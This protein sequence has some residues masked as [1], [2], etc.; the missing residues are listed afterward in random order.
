MKVV[1]TE[2]LSKIDQKPYWAVDWNG[3]AA[4][5]IQFLNGKFLA[6]V[7][8]VKGHVHSHEDY[9]DTLWGAVAHVVKAHERDQVE[10]GVSA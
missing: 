7:T 2:S 6:C 5:V 9:H 8:G 1:V 3:W 10:M 4:G